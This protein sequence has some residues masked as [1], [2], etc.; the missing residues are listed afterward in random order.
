MVERLVFEIDIEAPAKT[1]WYNLWSKETYTKWTEQFCEGSYYIGELIEGSRIH[2]LSPNG[3]G[4]F[5]DVETFKE[6]EV[7]NFK[8]LGEMKD[9]MEIPVTGDVSQWS[10]CHEIYMLTEHNGKTH[11]KVEVD[12]VKEFVDYMKQTWPIAINKLKEICL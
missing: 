7:V 2:F 11:L 1:V 12:V 10:G 6:N 8:H 4:I 5:S 3:Q 9:N